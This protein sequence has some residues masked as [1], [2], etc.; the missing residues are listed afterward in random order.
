MVLIIYVDRLEANSFAQCSALFLRTSI[1]ILRSF[2]ISDAIIL[3]VLLLFFRSFQTNASNS[4]SICKWVTHTQQ[5]FLPVLRK[6]LKAGNASICSSQTRSALA[7]FHAYAIRSLLSLDMSIAGCK[8]HTVYCLQF[9]L[10]SPQMCEPAY[11]DAGQKKKITNPF[12]QF[13]NF[14]NRCVIVVGTHN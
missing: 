6:S 3:F 5:S 14:V 8:L 1:R 10:Y 9:I 7:L 13:F 12:M 2:I 11:H 4:M